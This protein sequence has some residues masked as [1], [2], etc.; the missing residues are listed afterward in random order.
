MGA[1]ITIYDNQSTDS[2]PQII[3]D[4][5]CKLI[6]WDSEGQI[7]DDLYLSI[8]NEA[9][10]KSK[11]EWTV[12]VDLDEFI[13]IDFDIT[14]YN[15]IRTQGYDMIGSPPSRL[16]VPNNLY[17][18]AV[19]FRPNSFSQIGYGPGCHLFNPSPKEP[20]RIS[21]EIANLLHYKYISEEYVYNRHLMYQS[22]LSDLNKKY[23]WG[24]EYNNVQ[25]ELINKKFIDL[26]SS[27]QLLVTNNHHNV[28][29]TQ[30]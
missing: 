20:I 4:L 25:R 24:V 12:S 10:K 9:F 11:A 27:S 13:E 23:G 26:R 22:R 15:I 5:G 6:S 17:S 2:S 19:M 29:N 14:P 28:S 21:S 30:A 1:N 3:Q 16:S 8:K 7:R 18:K